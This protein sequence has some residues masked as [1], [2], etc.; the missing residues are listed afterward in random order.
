MTRQEQEHLKDN[1]K[2]NNNFNKQNNNFTHAADFFVHFL[3][4]FAWLRREND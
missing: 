3:S 4:V 1:N 2:R